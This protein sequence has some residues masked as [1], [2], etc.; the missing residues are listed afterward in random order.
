MQ[1]REVIKILIKDFDGDIESAK[2]AINENYIGEFSSRLDFI[3]WML[4]E[5]DEISAE[6]ADIVAEDYYRIIQ[7]K[8]NNLFDNKPIYVFYR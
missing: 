3:N 1:C 2:E 5:E 7:E 6:E 4:E 8:K